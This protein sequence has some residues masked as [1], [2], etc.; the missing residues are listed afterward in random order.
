MKTLEAQESVSE[1]ITTL[2]ETILP[3]FAVAY[4][5]ESPYSVLYTP[6][7]EELLKAIKDACSKS[8]EKTA[9]R[10]DICKLIEKDTTPISINLQAVSEMLTVEIEKTDPDIERVGQ[11]I[12][13][14]YKVVA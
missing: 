10:N 14:K 6:T 8:E 12:S 7:R 9:S 11:G 4:G 2:K 3:A 1:H 13:S 5:S